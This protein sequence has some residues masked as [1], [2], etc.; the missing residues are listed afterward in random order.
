MDERLR[1]RAQSSVLCGDRRRWCLRDCRGSPGEIYD[2]G[3]A[4]RT[5]KWKRGKNYRDGEGGSL[6]DIRT[7]TVSLGW[8]HES[9]VSQ[10][11]NEDFKHAS[12]SIAPDNPLSISPCKTLLPS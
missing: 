1:W 9:V 11:S 12:H 7:L 3:V 5:R 8:L 2:C 6:E 4:R 10:V